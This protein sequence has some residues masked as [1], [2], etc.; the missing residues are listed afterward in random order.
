MR[1]IVITYIVIG[2]SVVLSYDW[3]TGGFAPNASFTILLGVLVAAIIYIAS[4]FGRLGPSYFFPAASCPSCGRVIPADAN[5][6]PYCGHRVS[7]TRT[8]SEYRSA[9]A[10][11]ILEARIAGWVALATAAA[12]AMPTIAVRLTHGTLN[13]TMPAKYTR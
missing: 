8:H 2:L 3:S 6:C 13:T 12:E 5:L 4:R 1:A 11:G 9:S 10:G 7:V